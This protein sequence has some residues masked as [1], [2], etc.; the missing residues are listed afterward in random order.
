MVTFVHLHLHSCYS[1]RDSIIKPDDLIARLGEIEQNAVAIT[2]HGGSLG[3]VLLYKE[4]KASSIKMIHG[5]EAYICDDAK[6]K[7]K[8]NRYY[9]LVLLCKNETGRINLNRLITISE[10]PEN[11][12]YKPRIDFEIL[13]AHKDG[14]I[15]LSACLA[16]EVSRLLQADN[17]DGAKAVVAKYKQAFGADYF[18]EIQAHNDPEQIEVNKKILQLAKVT[19]TESVVTCDAHY[20][21]PDDKEYQNKFAFNGAYREQAGGAYVDCFVQSEDEVR[22]NL[23][24]LYESTVDRLIENTDSIAARC[25]V[26]IPL[27]APIMPEIAIPEGYVSNTEY[28][29]ALCNE[30]FENVLKLSTLPDSLALVYQERYQYELDSLKRMGF[31]DYILLVHSYANIT[32]R[33]GI[34]RGSGGGSLICYLIGITQIDPVEHGLL[35]ERFIDVGQLQALES[36]EIS[37]NELKVPDIDLDFATDTLGGIL[38]FLYERYGEDKVASIGRFGTNKTKGTIRDMAKVLGI[39]LKEADRIS[40]AFDDYEIDDI[41]SM[42]SGDIPTIATADIAISYVIRYKKLFD[43]VRKLNGLPKS[44]GLH[45]CGKIIAIKDLDNYLPSCYGSDGVRYL[46]GDMHDTDSLGLVKV[47]VLG[48]RTLNQQFD[49]HELSKESDEFLSTKQS[50]GDDKVMQLFRNTDTVG[51]FQFGSRGMQEVLK[52]MQV[53]N[54]DDLAIGNALFRPGPMQYIDEFCRRRTGHLKTEY[55]HSDLEPILSKTY[56]IMVFQEQLIQ[57]GRMAGLR[58]PDLLRKATGK[59]DIKLMAKVKP[60]LEAGLKLR[61]WSEKQITQL[62]KEMIEFSSYSFGKA[63]AYAYSM[64][65]YLTAK[66]K[67]YYPVEFFV[68]LLNSFIG[69]SSFVKDSADEIVSDIFKHNINI[70]LFDYHNDHRRCSVKDGAILY[71]IPLIKTCSQVV[72]DQV[73]YVSGIK[74]SHFWRVLK[75]LYANSVNTAQ[76]AILIR[77]GFFKAFGNESALI[78]I[79]SLYSNFGEKKQINASLAD[80]SPIWQIII[81]HSTN[82]G[83]NGNILKRR[84]IIDSNAMMDDFEK[85]CIANTDIEY[86]YKEK[87]DYQKGVLGFVSLLTGEEKDRP[88]LYV[89]SV[90]PAKRKADGKVFGHNIVA[91]SIGSGITSRYTIF[92]RVFDKEPLETGDVINCLAYSKKGVYYNMDNYARLV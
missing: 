20:V 68:G 18:L 65:A 55:I 28:L 4:L 33:R 3:S 40:K 75:Y 44:F 54:L 58:N 37:R 22:Q 45:P 71:A 63:H 56:G 52:K 38:H 72:A 30:G 53:K 85:E 26:D 89:K 5:M 47:D 73:Y 84:T 86:T 27:S 51:I 7:D 90:F 10:R 9:H 2:D 6:I 92:N 29:M 62:W 15:V 79:E 48:L 21:Y 83:K 69:E 35:F 1:L 59:K 12:Y 39:D 88:L 13:Q 70:L 11:K 67:A 64:L 91:Q 32:K 46:Q 24:Y 49:T 61:G 50:M 43:Y 41:D 57:I 34:A 16:G 19:N 80:N 77:L 87:A 76:M 8:D 78:R 81:K 60:E 74:L 14:L 17:Y 42:L 66:Q 31:V 25:N 82:I 36:G 23:S